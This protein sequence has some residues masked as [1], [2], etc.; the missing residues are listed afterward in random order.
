MDEPN[1]AELFAA[2][3]AGVRFEAIPRA[4][5]ERAKVFIAC[6]GRLETVD[7]V[8]VLTGMLG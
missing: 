1:A 7:D 8:R 2:H 3:T 4:A 5:I 6:V